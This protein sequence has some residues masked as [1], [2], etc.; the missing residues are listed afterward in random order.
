MVVGCSRYQQFD[1]TTPKPNVRDSTVRN[2]NNK[3]ISFQRSKS[4]N[5]LRRRKGRSCT[6]KCKRSGSISDAANYLLNVNEEERV[7]FIQ[8]SSM[9]TTVSS[10]KRSSSL[11]LKRSV[12]IQPRA[13]GCKAS[14]WTKLWSVKPTATDGRSIPRSSCSSLNER[15]A[16]SA[17][18]SY[19]KHNLSPAPSLEEK[20]HSKSLKSPYSGGLSGALARPQLAARHAIT[21]R[22]PWTYTHISKNSDESTNHGDEWAS[23][24]NLEQLFHCGIIQN[25]EYNIRKRQLINSLTG[26]KI[27]PLQESVMKWSML[28]RTTQHRRTLGE[29]SIVKEV[30]DWKQQP[31]LQAIR[32]SYN[33]ETKQW[34]KCFRR[35]K[36]APNAFNNGMLRCCFYMMELTHRESKRGSMGAL[37]PP[38]AAQQSTEEPTHVCKVYIDPF[39]ERKSYF[40]DAVM[41]AEAQRFAD[42]YNKLEVP[43][44][45]GFLEVSVYEIQDMPNSDGPIICN[46]EEYIKGDYIKHNNNWDWCEDLVAR[47]TPQTFSHYTYEASDRKLIVVDMQG[48]N[49]L[50]TD[51]QMHTLDKNGFGKGNMG[52]RGIEQFLKSHQCNAI[53]QFLRL[54]SRQ[55]QIGS[56]IE[57]TLP[58]K[59]FMTRL[60]VPTIQPST[61]ATNIPPEVDYSAIL[62]P[63]LKD[64]QTLGSEAKDGKFCSACRCIIQ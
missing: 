36:V 12:K 18:Y 30:P 4:S 20:Y 39:E 55:Y 27:A 49:D 17:D 8:R 44:K 29:Q 43:K 54:E 46:V 60:S 58:N 53:C 35:I 3:G 56:A 9:P 51:P 1:Y 28:H 52:I 41:Q 25:E 57:G 21:K 31:V 23:I 64:T 42:M 5:N 38:K 50:Y 14:T 16:V 11:D 33:A 40:N 47:N 37:V 22:Y 62:P 32:W 45:V 10:P 7:P 15:T 61:K 63:L 19:F 13:S 59:R 2:A 26:T 48:V 6:C 24:V 34:Q